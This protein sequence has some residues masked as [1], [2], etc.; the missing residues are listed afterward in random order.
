MLIG[1]DGSLAKPYVTGIF[2]GSYG[3]INGFYQ[4][5][6]VESLGEL[7][8]GG[9]TYGQ[10]TASVGE[11]NYTRPLSIACKLFIRYM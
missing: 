6:L 3:K 7:T 11:G 8:G 9:F 2:Q 5:A 1:S 4:R 10:I